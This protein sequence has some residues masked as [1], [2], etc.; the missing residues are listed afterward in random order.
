MQFVQ[1]TH[2]HSQQKDGIASNVYFTEMLRNLPIIRFIVA[3]RV[4][5]SKRKEKKEI[6]LYTY[7]C[8]ENPNLVQ[9]EVYKG[10]SIIFTSQIGTVAKS[11]EDLRWRYG[12]G[13]RLIVT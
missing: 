3:L 4:C 9:A 11:T 1:K 8:V 2:T 12:A 7:I 5:L 6:R 13:I 10:F